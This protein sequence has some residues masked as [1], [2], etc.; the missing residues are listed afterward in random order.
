MER[1]ESDNTLTPYKGNS[2]VESG[3]RSRCVSGTVDAEVP[4]EAEE[5]G[6]RRQIVGQSSVDG[7]D[8]GGSD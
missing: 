3:A 6:G 7:S 1:P 8:K 2:R 4:E 5:A